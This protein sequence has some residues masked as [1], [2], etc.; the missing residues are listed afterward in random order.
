MKAEEKILKKWDVNGN[1][2]VLEMD[3]Y[4]D[5]SRIP[6]ER[7]ICWGTD[8]EVLHYLVSLHNDRI[9]E[10][11]RRDEAVDKEYR[12]HCQKF[13]DRMEPIREEAMKFSE[14]LY[15]QWKSSEGKVGKGMAEACGCRKSKEAKE[16]T[17]RKSYIEYTDKPNLC[18]PELLYYTGTGPTWG[19]DLDGKRYWK[20][21]WPSTTKGDRFAHLSPGDI[22]NERARIKQI[23]SDL[24]DN[25]G[26]LIGI[27]RGIA[28]VEIKE[29]MRKK[30]DEISD[31][32]YQIEQK[33]KTIKIK[34]ELIEGIQKIIKKHLKLL[35]RR[36]RLLIPGV[37]RV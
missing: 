23:V 35:E 26:C 16:P 12:E 8:K 33:D 3:S 21:Y 36:Q 34:D 14:W 9:D 25:R 37:K 29:R 7:R 10:F 11:A 20:R 24:I 30:D 5:L 27:D 19:E 32:K 15:E 2:I 13:E 18:D 4:N 28:E 22:V 6:E 31:L 17:K 1:Q